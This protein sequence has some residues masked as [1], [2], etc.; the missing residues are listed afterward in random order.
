MIED[1]DSPGFKSSWT[2]TEVNSY[3]KGLMESDS[4]LRD[5]WV[6]GEVSNLSR[7][8]SGHLYFTL[9]DQNSQLRCVMWK[10]QAALLRTP[11]QDGVAVEA[12]GVVSIY[13]QRGQYQLYVDRIRPRG[14]GALF[15]EYLRLK[16][17]LEGEGLFDPERK[18]PIPTWPKRIGMV[19]SPSGAAFQDMK[20][21]LERRYP[22]VEVLLSPT[23]V[24]GESAPA[25]IIQALERL[26][27]IKPDLILI[28]RGGGSIEDLWAFNDEGLA[29]KLAQSPVPVI[30]GVGHETDFTLTD[31]VADLRAPTP[32]AAAELAVPDQGDLRGG[33]GELKIRVARTIQGL[34]MEQR[35]RLENLI[36]Q[37]NRLSP[38]GEINNSRQRLDELSTRLERGLVNGLKGFRD[39][40]S[41][42]GAR[43]GALNPESILQ[44]GYAVVT[45]E[46]GSLI[47]QIEQVESGKHLNVRVSDGDFDVTVD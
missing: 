21:T 5:L 29:R 42:L 23:S 3:L 38:L 34:L 16:D 47:Y 8:A 25:E 14:E 17:Q 13:E 40:C 10:N 15:Q 45:A 36:N 18:R 31:F 24:Q 46:D 28:G 35:L 39:R 6:E 12:H 26:Y 44:R 33:L 30:S 19:T 32:T 2:V 7:P 27:Q 37:V 20:D 1:L 9:K 22:L 43:L 41:A 11:L 4:N